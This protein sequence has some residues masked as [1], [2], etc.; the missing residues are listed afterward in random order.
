MN[1]GETTLDMITPRQSYSSIKQYILIPNVAVIVQPIQHSGRC[2]IASLS[3]QYIDLA[4]HHIL[5]VLFKASQNL[6]VE[7]SPACSFSS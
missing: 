4:S 7:M 1:K 3:T 5:K 6:L 2:V